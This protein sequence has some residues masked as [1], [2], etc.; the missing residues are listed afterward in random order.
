MENFLYV[1]DLHEPI[2][3]NEAKP[4]DLDDRKWAQL[5]QKVVSIIRSWIDQ[6]AYHHVV[7]E[8]MVDVVQ[9]KLEAIY[10]Q[11][12]A[13]YKVNLMKMLVN[14]KYKGGRDITK[15]ISEFQGLVNQLTTMKIILND[16]LQALL[17]LSSLPNNQKTLVVLVNNSESN[18]KL[19]LDIVIDR[20]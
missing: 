3:G 17:L 8:S 10:E 12:T 20:L 11:L 6:S 2:K 14:L 16:E 18:E 19:T 9:R 7:K 4:T 1:K 13:H 15:H 5:N